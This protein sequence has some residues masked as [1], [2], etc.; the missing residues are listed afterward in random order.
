M[1][2]QKRREMTA[3]EKARLDFSLKQLSA[4]ITAEVFFDMAMR[5]GEPVEPEVVKFVREQFGSLA[6]TAPIKLLESVPLVHKGRG[7]AETE[8]RTIAKANLKRMQAAQAD[9]QKIHDIV[10]K[11]Y[12]L[13]PELRRA[14]PERLAREVQAVLKRQGITR[15]TK[16]IRRA[17]PPKN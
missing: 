8:K 15:S 14:K 9:R 7:R 6:S 12:E 1:K 10:L 13:K 5:T 16:T 11:L 4:A 2:K 3:D 17:F